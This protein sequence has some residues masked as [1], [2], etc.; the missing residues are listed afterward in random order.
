MESTQSSR[1]ELDLLSGH[2][3]N[4]L[5]HIGAIDSSALHWSIPQAQTLQKKEGLAIEDSEW[6]SGLI[7]A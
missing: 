6:S 3:I 1:C 4:V 5:K 7:A 2:E